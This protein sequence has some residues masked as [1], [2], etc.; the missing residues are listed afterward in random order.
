VESVISE[1][2][3]AAIARVN[4]TLAIYRQQQRASSAEDDPISA[5]LPHEFLTH[6]AVTALMA[7]AEEFSLSRLIDLTHSTARAGKVVELLWDSELNRSGD[8]WGNREA[9]WERYFNVKSGGFQQRQSLLGFIDARNAIAHGHGSL[10]RKQLRSE[11]KT[12]ARL[13][14]AGIPTRGHAIELRAPE[15]EACAALVKGYVFWLDGAVAS[16]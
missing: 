3:E 10:T 16:A 5:S 9:M 14:Q 7:V 2:A 8:T 4:R 1:R 13:S 15:V 12:L 11:Q 6:A